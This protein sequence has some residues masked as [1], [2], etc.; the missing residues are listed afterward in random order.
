[1]TKAAFAAYLGAVAGAMLPW[2]ER[3]P[4]TM[5]RAPDGVEGERYFQKSAPTYA[6][7]W[8]RTVVIPAPSAKRDVRYV[9]CDDEATLRWLGNQ[10]VLE[11]HPAP[12]RV[13]RL[14][15]PDL[16]VVDVDPPQGRFDMAVEVASVVLEVLDELELPVG[17]KTT[18]GNGLHV[19]ASIERRYE[20]PDLRGAASELTRIVAERA[21]GLV[22]AEFRKD[23]RGGR[24]LLDPSRNAPGATFVA[25]Y[26][27]RAREHAPV[28]FPL[29]REEL[30][31]VSPSDFTIHTVPGLLQ[32]RGPAAWAELAAT[33]SRLP[34]R[35]LV[36]APAFSPRAGR[37]AR[38][39]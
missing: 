24:V 23:D 36:D 12:V 20:T 11:F 26:S 6:P 7:P 32:G 28:S 21:P 38:S 10:A 35:L 22:T 2:L 3:R 1:V 9:V 14:E 5:I 27:P 15:R 25:P 8:I 17:L 30:G 19:V 18:G 37:R 39:R 13:D 31:T 29:V 33:R 34:R 16:F 4:L